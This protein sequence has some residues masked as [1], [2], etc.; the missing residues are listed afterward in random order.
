MR[1]RSAAHIASHAWE[2]TTATPLTFSELTER[3]GPMTEFVL[4]NNTSRIPVLSRKSLS[5]VKAYL[6]EIAPAVK[7][8]EKDAAALGIEFVPI[9]YRIER[10][11]G[12]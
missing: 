9:K 3:G 4:W 8:I 10:V 5:E 11:C 2:A 6:R 1:L 7:A 12:S